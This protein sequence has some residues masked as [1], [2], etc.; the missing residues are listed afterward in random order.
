[1]KAGKTVME[2]S[3]EKNAQ[4]HRLKNTEN[5]SVS[6]DI[7][8]CFLLSAS[9]INGQLTDD[10]SFIQICPYNTKPGDCFSSKKDTV[11]TQKT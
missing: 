5:E 7:N 6:S 2:R 9:D 11:K 3:E 4:K 8:F 1:M 10:H